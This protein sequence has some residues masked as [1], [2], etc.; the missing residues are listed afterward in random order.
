M[1]SNAYISAEN[2]LWT[3]APGAQ[4]FCVQQCLGSERLGLR[5]DLD[6]AAGLFAG[7]PSSLPWPPSLAPGTVASAFQG[8]GVVSTQ[9]ASATVEESEGQSKD[10]TLADG[11]VFSLPDLSNHTFQYSSCGGSELSP[12]LSVK[13]GQQAVPALSLAYFDDSQSSGDIASQGSTVDYQFAIRSTI[14]GDYVDLVSGV[15][16]KA[17]EDIIYY[18]DND[19]IAI[20]QPLVIGNTVA[21]PG[22]T[23][24]APVIGQKGLAWSLIYTFQE[25]AFPGFP[26]SNFMR[27]DNGPTPPGE[28]YVESLARL[29]FNIASDELGCAPCNPG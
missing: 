22:T 13:V 3:V 23:I 29:Y 1:S 10:V 24:I 18:I 2:P 15:I 7:L 12:T 16:F 11:L 28:V 21:D 19:T 14:Q 5:P 8:A 20:T 6:P 26:V 25:R 4:A 9:P 17:G 27:G